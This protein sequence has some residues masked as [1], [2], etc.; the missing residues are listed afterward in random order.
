MGILLKEANSEFSALFK[1]AP[2]VISKGQGNFETLSEEERPI[3]FLLQV[4]CAVVAKILSSKVR[5]FILSLNF[6]KLNRLVR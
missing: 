4:K 6:K 1:E 5:D 3:F 2:F